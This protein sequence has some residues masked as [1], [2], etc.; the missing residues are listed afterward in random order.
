MRVGGRNDTELGRTSADATP[1][2]VPRPAPL[3]EIST[4]GLQC[5]VRICCSA[6]TD[7]SGF[8]RERVEITSQ[9]IDNTYRFY[10]FI[11]FCI[12]IARIY[13][14]FRRP[15]PGRIS[16]VANHRGVHVPDQYRNQAVQGLRLSEW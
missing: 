6:K 13:H 14:P 12:L 15:A 8:L 1:G 5:V 7:A 9:L 11:R 10:N 16:P 3:F 2:P 4:G